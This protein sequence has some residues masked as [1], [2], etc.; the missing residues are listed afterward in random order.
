MK[1]VEVKEAQEKEEFEKFI[2]GIKVESVEDAIKLYCLFNHMVV[3][4]CFEIPYDVHVKIREYILHKCPAAGNY[5][6]FFEK[7]D[8]KIHRI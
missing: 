6:D 5:E 7:A 8:N 3:S 4:D 1:I 2:L